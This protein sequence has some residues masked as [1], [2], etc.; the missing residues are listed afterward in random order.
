MPP[1]AKPVEV[2]KKDK[3]ERD[4]WLTV[5]SALQDAQGIRDALSSLSWETGL[6]PKTVD[7]V[8]LAL[9]R[10]AGMSKYSNIRVY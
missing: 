1:A 6:S 4:Q 3:K 7:T 2:D 5:Q 9:K 8:E 10:A